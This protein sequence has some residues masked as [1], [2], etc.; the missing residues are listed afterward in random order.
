M[1]SSLLIKMIEA[2]QGSRNFGFL[3]RLL[4]EMI[5]IVVYKFLESMI[6]DS[7][8]TYDGEAEAF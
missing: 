8:R 7:I 3:S 4:E 2:L 5:A 1:I 6:T